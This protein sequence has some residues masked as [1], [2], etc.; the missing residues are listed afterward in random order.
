MILKMC[1]SFFLLNRKI[2]TFPKWRFKPLNWR[3]RWMLNTGVFHLK[4]VDLEERKT[5]R[6]TSNN[7]EEL[8]Q[9]LSLSL[10]DKI[11]AETYITIMYIYFAKSLVLIKRLHDDWMKKICTFFKPMWLKKNHVTCYIFFF[12]LN[13]SSTCSHCFVFVQTLGDW[14]REKVTCL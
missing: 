9:W 11:M 7:S 2:T 10:M 3:T 13:V 8:A 6:L 5:L 14:M 4:Q 1:A 12:A